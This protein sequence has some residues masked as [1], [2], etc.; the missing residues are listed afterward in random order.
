MLLEEILS[1][2]EFLMSVSTHLMAFAS[3][4]CVPRRSVPRIA[5]NELKF[6]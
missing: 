4:V 5:C 1:I 3:A 2:A 6:L